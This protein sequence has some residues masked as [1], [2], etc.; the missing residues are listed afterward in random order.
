MHGIA[1]AAE[2]GPTLAEAEVKL[3][4]AGNCLLSSASGNLCLELHLA[5]KYGKWIGVLVRGS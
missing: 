2:P 3:G 4:R 1:V 5:L